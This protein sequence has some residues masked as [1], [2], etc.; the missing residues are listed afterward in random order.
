[1]NLSN[2]PRSYRSNRWRWK[3]G[4]WMELRRN[5]LTSSNFGKVIKRRKTNP[6]ANMVKNMLYRPNLSHVTSIHHGI[7]N[8]P[9]ARE[10]LSEILEE[11][12]SSCGLFIDKNIPYFGASPDGII[13]RSNTLIEI[14][15][16]LAPYKMGID[17]A[18]KNHKMHFWRYNKKN[19]EITI[20]KNS[21]WYYQ[22][23]GQ[24][25]IC[26]VPKCILAIWYGDKKIKIE[27]IEEDKKFWVE[28]MEPKLTEFYFDCLLPELI[29]PR[30]T[31]G[32]E[33]RE[34]SYV[35]K[36]DKKGV[37]NTET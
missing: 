27:I 13:K 29:D 6:C 3:S 30:L 24:M 7:T 10:Q 9:I 11:E 23:Q 12:I 5:L 1:M 15:C 16:P 33:I 19:N 32:R 31:R 21:D 37:K 18:I 14:K 2:D 35:V 22:V 8:E 26:E 28:K 20:N 4:E 34:P 25:H 36:K 17:E